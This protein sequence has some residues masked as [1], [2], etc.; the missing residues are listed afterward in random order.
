[1]VELDVYIPVFI[2]AAI[3][4]AVTLVMY[5]SRSHAS[6]ALMQN[7]LNY[8]KHD[9]SEGFTE[10]KD[11]IK[12]KDALWSKSRDMMSQKIDELGREQE[13]QK[14]KISEMKLDIASLRAYRN[15]GSKTAI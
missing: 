1:L 7:D 3:G 8:I 13:L 9:V 12:E 15:G 10:V 11:L 14:Y 5:F 4:I 2:S 6:S